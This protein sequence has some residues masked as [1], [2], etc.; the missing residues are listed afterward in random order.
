MTQ[1]IHSR[2]FHCPTPGSVGPVRPPAWPG[3]GRAP[4]LSSVPVSGLQADVRSAAAASGFPANVAICCWVSG[5]MSRLFLSRGVQAQVSSVPWACSRVGSQSWNL[6]FSLVR[7]PT[8][9]IIR[10]WVGVPSWLFACPCI[11][12]WIPPLD[13]HAWCC[14]VLC[15]VHARFTF[16][17]ITLFNINNHSNGSCMGRT[18]DRGGGHY[19]K[20]IYAPRLLLHYVIIVT[21]IAQG[22]FWSLVLNFIS[23]PWFNSVALRHMNYLSV[24]PNGFCSRFSRRSAVPAISADKDSHGQLWLVEIIQPVTCGLHPRVPS[25]MFR[26]F[27][28]SGSGA[29]IWFDSVC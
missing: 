13:H 7:V 26:S 10:S 2:V 29:V 27:W 20:R 15:R 12:F 5:L 18:K 3:D 28:S 8:R 14:L 16:L 22:R 9:Y 17:S 19:D 25:S 4:L 11:G 23:G 21:V 24:V 1:N 6:T